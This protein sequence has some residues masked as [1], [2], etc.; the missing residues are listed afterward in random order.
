MVNVLSAADMQQYE[1]AMSWKAHDGEVYSV[2]FSYD[3][4]TVFSIGE[5]GKVCAPWKIDHRLWNC[6]RFEV[7]FL[8]YLQFIQW[9]I[10][11]C[12][13]KQSEQTLPQDATGP[14]ILSGY[15]GYKQVRLTH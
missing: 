2:E 9:N 15:S 5:D 8:M 10:H 3:E 14:F 4:N 13:V 1:S 12:G 6:N 11:R 7:F